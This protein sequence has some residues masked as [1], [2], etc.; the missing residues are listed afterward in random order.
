MREAN[1]HSYPI[2]KENWKIYEAGEVFYENN[3]VTNQE[4]LGLRLLVVA[5]NVG[6]CIKV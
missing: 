4:E 3:T 1:L 5:N 6:K 2:T